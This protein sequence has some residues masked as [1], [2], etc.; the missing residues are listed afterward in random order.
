MSQISGIWGNPY[1]FLRRGSFFSVIF[2]H[3]KIK[4]NDP[5]SFFF[6][7]SNYSTAGDDPR[8]LFYGVRYSFIYRHQKLP[9]NGCFVELLLI[10]LILSLL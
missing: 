4:K 6:K 1:L 3:V 2:D 5:W 10:F 9:A 7:I 8:S